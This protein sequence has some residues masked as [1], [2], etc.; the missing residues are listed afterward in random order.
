[1]IGAIAGDIIGSRFEMINHAGDKKLDN[2]LKFP[3]FTEK[4]RFTDDSVLSIAVA[5][6]LMHNKPFNAT[7]KE[8]GRKYPA[9]G[10]GSSFMQWLDMPGLE[11]NNS[12]G[13][14][15]AMRVSP[16]GFYF[17]DLDKVLEQAEK[18]AY[19]THSHEEG[20]KGAQAIAV[21]VFLAR[22]GASKEEI[23]NYIKEKFSYN[24]D[25]TLDEIRP[26]YEFSSKAFDTV[27]E[28]IIAFLES[29]DYENAI[30]KAISIGGDSDTLACMAGAI[31]EAFYGIEN[32]P[33]EIIKQT[34]EILAG[35]APEL[36]K[37]LFKF[38]I[39]VYTT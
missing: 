13:N 32:I 11:V 29:S 27:P 22:K 20:I 17:N 25:R 2:Y 3:L 33:Y 4:C 18:S 23:K 16:I 26:T 1:M 5:D 36:H 35:T 7:L 14:G 8:Y 38:E 21:A 34:T 6:C 37:L 19:P 31:S 12:Y 28:A 30:R 15:S 9:A 39:N 24:L 10:Y